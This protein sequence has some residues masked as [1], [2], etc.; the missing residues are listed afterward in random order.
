MG[1]CDSENDIQLTLVEGLAGSLGASVAIFDRDDTLIYSSRNFSRFFALP[2]DSLKVGIRLRDFL[3]AIYDSGARFGIAAKDGSGISR[4][5]W[6][7]E[8]IAVHWRERH[9]NVEQLPDGRWVKL[10]KRR[11]P[12]GMLITH[13]SDV[14][15][16]K[17][18]DHD[19]EAA[20]E[21]A[22]LAR[23][24]FDNLPNP[25]LVKDE[26]MHI[27]LVNKAFC[28]LLGFEQHEIIGRRVADLVGKEAAGLFEERERRVLETG[29]PLEFVEDI[30]HP[31]GSLI[32]SITRKHRIGSPGNYFV[33]I[34]VDRI[35]TQSAVNQMRR[36]VSSVS[37]SPDKPGETSRRK[38]LVVDQDLARAQSRAA[39]LRSD[40][41]EVMAID[42]LRQLFSFLDTARTMDVKIDSIEV[43]PELGAALAA[44]PAAAEYPVLAR[45]LAERVSRDIARRTAEA[46]APEGAEPHL[47]EQ[48]A[49][50]TCE[51]EIV[52]ETPDPSMEPDETPTEPVADGDNSR[53][54]RPVIA[55]PSRDEALPRVSLAAQAMKAVSQPQSPSG[56][57]RILVAEDNDVNQIVFEQ[58]LDT[59][60]ADYHIVANGEEAIDSW[61]SFKPDLI[62]MDV[63]MPV[64]NGHEATRRIREEEN[65]TDGGTHTPILA[66]TAHAMAGDADACFAA[67][68]DD[69]M[70][71]PISPEKL[72]HSISTWVHSGAR[73]ARAS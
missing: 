14:T 10:G 28:R 26:S 68:M 22:K 6:I 7:A 27:V 73:S 12:G 62:L 64:M 21:H 38:V 29:E 42:D 25:V 8:R 65:G 2:E 3:G 34:S 41:L 9:E 47:G 20:Q 54:D 66:V 59:I 40:G 4:N 56:K 72:E 35:T 5:D 23:K 30:P 52:P 33:T 60:G 16:Q 15:E 31:D 71:K 69:Y 32:R 53:P 57:V 1:T 49:Q 63:S 51:P 18:R 24:T 46:Q 36:H 19:F 45:L 17:R 37:G 67:G 11:M 61:R 50:A 58:I 48:P 44:N 39:V 13:I 55:V 43:T 70:T